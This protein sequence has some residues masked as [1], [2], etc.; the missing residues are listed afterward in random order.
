MECI[1]FSRSPYAVGMFDG[2]ACDRER[3]I[4]ESLVAVAASLE[5]RFEMWLAGLGR[6]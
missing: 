1:D 6:G 4:T 5:E 2:N 3:P